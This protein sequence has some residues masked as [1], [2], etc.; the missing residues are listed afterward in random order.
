MGKVLLKQIEFD[1]GEE[2]YILCEEECLIF[3]WNI[4][5]LRRYYKLFQR[6]EKFSLVYKDMELRIL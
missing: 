6:V 3:V 2:L 1:S 5:C 4:V